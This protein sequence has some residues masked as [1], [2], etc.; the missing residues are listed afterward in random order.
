MTRFRYIGRGGG[1][2]GR[3][4]TQAGVILPGDACL[5]P[6]PSGFRVVRRAHGHEP[7]EPCANVR[8]GAD[9]IEV[10]DGFD[11][12]ARSFRGARGINGRT[13]YEEVP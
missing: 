12:I 13:L 5:D 8:R 4:S 11:L 10:P 7:G 6:M 1:G 2:A 9:L 3:P